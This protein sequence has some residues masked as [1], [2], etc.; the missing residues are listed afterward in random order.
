VRGDVSTGGRLRKRSTP[1][2]KRD[3]GQRRHTVSQRG[4]WSRG[5]ILCAALTLGLMACARKEEE[6]RYAVSYP[7]Q[8]SQTVTGTGYAAYPGLPAPPVNEEGVVPPPP[9]RYMGES[10]EASSGNVD[11]R[12]DVRGCLRAGWVLELG[13]CE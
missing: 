8:P 9:P 6:P 4:S 7:G 13:H 10:N 12:R 1:P 2:V 3:G 5:A 11:V